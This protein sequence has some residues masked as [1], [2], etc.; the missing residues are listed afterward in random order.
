MLLLMNADGTNIRLFSQTTRSTTRTLRR[1]RPTAA[2]L[3][4]PE[5]F[6]ILAAAANYG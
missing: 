6:S 2:R 1:G 4:L 5:P 3:L